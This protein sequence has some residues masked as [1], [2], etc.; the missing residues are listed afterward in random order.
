MRRIGVSRSLHCDE[1]KTGSVSASF[2]CDPPVAV[3]FAMDRCARSGGARR[4][5]TA[6]IDAAWCTGTKL[7]LKPGMSRASGVV[8]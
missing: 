1:L 5:R 4:H 2:R 3:L 7:A 6:R 8:R